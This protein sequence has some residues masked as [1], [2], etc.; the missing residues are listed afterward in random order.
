MI[1]NI[2]LKSSF[3]VSPIRVIY[4]SDKFSPIPLIV[5]Y[6]PFSILDKSIL[7]SF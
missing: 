1:F 6:V 5:R 3:V 4:V 7:G 2:S